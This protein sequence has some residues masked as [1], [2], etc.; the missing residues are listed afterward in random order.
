MVTRSRQ[1]GRDGCVRCDGTVRR[2]APTCRSVT[3]WP[4]RAGDPRSTATPHAVHRISP[5]GPQEVTGWT[6][7]G[8]NLLTL[9]SWKPRVGP[10]SVQETSAETRL[11]PAPL[12]RYMAWSARASTSCPSSPGRTSVTPTLAV[13]PAPAPTRATA[14]RSRPARVDLRQDGELV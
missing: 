12:A 2:S 7:Q 8:R 10:A 1:C 14:S 5:A 11:P 3:Y 6:G 9:G 13:T 4:V